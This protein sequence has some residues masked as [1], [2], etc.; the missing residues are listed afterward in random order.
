[1]K[2]KD[3]IK[4]TWKTIN[5]ILSKTKRKHKFPNLFMENGTPITDTLDIAN[6]FNN[7]FYKYWSLT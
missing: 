1:M 4:G 5:G 7:F 6:N 2:L 3:N